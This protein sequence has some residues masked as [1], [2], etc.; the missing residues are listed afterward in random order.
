MRVLIVLCCLFAQFSVE[1][2]KKIVLSGIV[3]NAESEALVGANVALY[4]EA[5]SSLI[6]GKASGAKGA[7]KIDCGLINRCYLQI[8][9]LGYKTQR[10]GLVNVCENQELGKILL[11]TNEM[12]TDEVQIIASQQVQEL[13]RMI[14]YPDRVQVKQS[15]T[16]LDLLANMMLPGLSVNTVERTAM[17]MDKAVE[18]RVNGR[19]VNVKDVDALIASN[20]QKVEYIDNPGLDYGRAA[21]AVVNYITKEPVSGFTTS[22]SL[23]NAVWVGF[24]NDLLNMRWNHKRSEF[25]VSYNTM[26]R[27]YKKRL[28]DQTNQYIFPDQMEILRE[29]IGE[30][31]PFKSQIHNLNLSYGLMK[32]DDYLFSVIGRFAYEYNDKN[33]LSSIYENGI[34]N[35]RQSSERSTRDILPE[36]DIYFSKQ[37]TPRQDFSLNIVGGYVS[38]DLDYW[39]EEESAEHYFTS[40]NADASRYNLIGEF[41]YNNRFA[42][43]HRFAIG[44]NEKYF[45]EKDQYSNESMARTTKNNT[46]FA[47]A[48]LSGS[49]NKFIYNIGFAGAMSRYDQSVRDFTFWSFQPGVNLGYRFSKKSLLRYNLKISSDDPKVAYLNDVVQVVNPYLRSQGNPDLSAYNI[50]DNSLVYSFTH[51]KMNIQLSGS[52]LY[53]YNPVTDYIYYDDKAGMFVNNYQNQGSMKRYML[54][55]YGRYSG[56]FNNILTLSARVRYSHYKTSGINYRHHLNNLSAQFEVNATYKDFSL[57]VTADTRDKHLMGERLEF[58][59][60]S[61]IALLQY[62]KKHFI[63]G[64]GLYYPFAKQWDAGSDL[65]SSITPQK[66]WTS[67]KD[68][69]RM[70]F[71]RLSWNFSTGRSY[72]I[73][74]KSLKNVGGTPGL[75][76]M[77]VID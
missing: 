13:D 61:S 12:M 31:T 62:N 73:S 23:L 28:N 68:N 17:A 41:K 19:K 2:Q 10:L 77:P 53:M 11:E 64:L 20:I 4:N 36:L 5:D 24:G 33:Y 48:L 70:L 25:G 66:S 50:Y 63:V 44:V 21:G 22:G 27:K 29:Y 56:L 8:S 32:K 49:F 59:S 34:F 45:S 40:F 15:A 71:V 39:Y 14:V 57:R 60:L 52:H 30:N 58:R 43:N 7:F 67:I 18:F 55:A 54:T 74:N 26:F 6:T 35:S 75:S 9:F 38:S 37:I 72:K 1:A 65:L 47:Y 46:V 69:G 51:K 42:K 76:S 3:V 16:P